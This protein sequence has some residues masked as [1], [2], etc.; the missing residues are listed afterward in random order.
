MIGR[1]PAWQRRSSRL[2]HPA[3]VI[4]VGFGTAV[5]VGTGLLSLPVATRSGERTGLVDALFTATSAVCVTG[6]VTVDTGSYWSGFGQAV[7]LLLIQA[8]GLGIMTLATLF[9]VLLSRRL[10]LRARFLAQAETKSLDLTD[11]RAVVRRIV[12][13]SL[14]GEAVVA[15]VLTARFATAYDEPFGEAVYDGVFHAVSAFNNAGFSTNADSLVGYVADPWICLPIAAAVILGGLGFPVVF[16]LLRCWRRP[17]LWSVLTRITLALTGALLVLGTV[18]LTLAEFTNP[19]TL[20]P[21]HGWHKLLAGFFASTMTRTAGFNSVDIGAMRPESLLAS[22]VLMFIGG[23]SAG[24]AGGIKVTTFGLLAFVLWS[25]M[26]GELHV[27]VGRRGIPASNQRQALA[28]ALLSVGAVVTATFALLA[29]T[30]YRLD[31]VLFE[32]VSAFATVGLS[33]GITASLPPQADLLLVVL[34]FAGRVGPLTL[35]SALA[36]RDRNRRFELPEE[37]TIVG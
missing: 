27:N 36:L 11:V 16:E 29:T 32:A 12:L 22:D 25:E 5:V 10:G 17:A 21:L 33:T 35:A 37:R 23:G 19:R 24:T 28:V 34:M 26:R 3:Q 13:F 9:T 4:A 2:R 18:V 14:A 1:A 7:I 15:V 30:P 8:G 20:G 6:L 31:V